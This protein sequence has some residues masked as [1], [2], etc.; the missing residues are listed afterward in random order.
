MKRYAQT[1]G[2]AADGY[3]DLTRG[4]LLK[5]APVIVPIRSHAGDHFVVFRGAVGGQAILAEAI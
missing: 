3:L 2:F 4:Q 1:R 5:L